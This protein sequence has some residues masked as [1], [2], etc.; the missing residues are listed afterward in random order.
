[1]EDFFKYMGISRTL[2]LIYCMFWMFSPADGATVSMVVGSRAIFHCANESISALAQLT[3]KKDGVTLFSL[4]PHNPIYASNETREL[5]INMSESESKLYPLIIESVQTSHGGN[6]T[7]ET[8]SVTGAWEEQWEL[9]IIEHVE[10]EN[11]HTTVIAVAVPCVCCLIFIITLTVLH[12]VRKRRG[13][14]IQETIQ[15]PAAERHQAK[16]EDIYENCLESRRQHYN[17][18]YRPRAH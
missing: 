2:C 9:I 14:I 18:H 1:M 3:W 8:N 4:K 10:G 16:T 13:R 12:G 5:N 7:C 6:Y 11:R 15:A 17:K